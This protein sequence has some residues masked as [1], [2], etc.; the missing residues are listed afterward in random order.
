MDQIGGKNMAHAIIRGNNGRRYNVDF[1][2]S[3][4]CVEIYASETTI[5]MFVEA[6]FE[7]MPEERRRFAVINVPRDQFSQAT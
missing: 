1:S 3:P 7:T 5:E 4:V 6:D 2:D